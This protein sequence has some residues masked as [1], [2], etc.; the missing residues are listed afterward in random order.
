[1][2]AATSAMMGAAETSRATHTL[3]NLL[4]DW[5]S[6]E[7]LRRCGGLPITGLTDDSRQVRPGYVFVAVNGTQAD[8]RRFVAEAV[9][10]GAAVVV[11]ED[12]SADGHAAVVSVADARA[13]LTTLALRW[14]GLASDGC[15]GLKLLGITG[16]NGKSTT[17]F[18]TRAILRAAGW[19][20]GL[21]GTVLYDLCGRNVTA[22]MTTPGPLELVSHLRECA[23]AGAKA[24][25]LEVSSHALAQKRTDG[26][27]FAAAAFT[28]LTG[29]HLDY[30]GTPENYRAAKRRLF[31][32][33][34]GEAVA[35][36]NGDDPQHEHL[37]AGCRA[38]RKS[39]V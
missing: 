27:R 21:L 22:R 10:R 23:D 15:A 28:N 25:V 31:E 6:P 33:L 36:V 20:C 9:Q 24:A 1:M 39:V 2:Q 12:L 19:K 37:V 35:V 32:N 38:D 13:A 8:G 16:T 26:L 17:A 11:G 5:A 30:H 34:D 3:G 14:H 7:L 18:M 4:T 29:D